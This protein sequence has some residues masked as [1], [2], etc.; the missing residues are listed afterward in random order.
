MNLEIERDYRR[1][2]VL[3]VGGA[4]GG[5]VFGLVI[6]AAAIGGCR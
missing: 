5:I 4:V 1:T 3:A 2:L 6:M